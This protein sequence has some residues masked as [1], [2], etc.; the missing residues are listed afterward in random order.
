M[1]EISFEIEGETVEPDGMKDVLDILFLEHL[2]Q[3]LQNSLAAVR[4]ARHDQ[5]PRIK[6]KGQSLDQLTYEVSGCCSN[7]IEETREKIR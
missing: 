1:A 5:E 2:R 6:V 7:L 3:E 4:C